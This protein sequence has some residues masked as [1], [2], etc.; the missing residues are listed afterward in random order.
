MMLFLKECRKVLFSIPF[1][2]VVVVIVAFSS[3]QGVFPKFSEPITKPQATDQSFGMHG[4]DIPEVV[5]P[6]AIASL[7]REFSVNQYS[8]YPIGFYKTV[9][10]NDK[11]QA[12]MAKILATLSGKPANEILQSAKIDSTSGAML[13]MGV[14]E[15]L[16]LD[17]DGNISVALSDDG[18]NAPKTA[19]NITAKTGLDYTDFKVQMA[20]ADKLIGSGSMYSEGYLL[21]NFGQVPI[22]FEEAIANYNLIKNYDKFSGAYSRLFSDYLGIML[23]II[24]VFIA[25]ALFLK[26]RSAKMNELV[27]SR[28]VPAWHVVSSRFFA[29]ITLVMIPTI[30]ICYIANASMWGMHSGEVIDYLAPLKYSLGWMLP[31]IM[32]SSAVG[33]FFT[34]LTDTPIAIIIQGFWW[35]IDINL[36]VSNIHGRYEW[37]VLSPR[38]NTIQA[39]NFAEKLSTLALNRSIFSLVAIAL[40]VATIYVYSQKRKGRLNG[41]DHFKSL[42]TN[43]KNKPTT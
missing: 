30:T 6:A 23:S 25:V 19:G 24:P 2:V 41:Y 33:M 36:G 11:K 16:K 34:V 7:Y 13:T 20:A 31:S 10:L 15:T 1:A 5:V 4:K 29:I 38:H 18:G 32:I 35:F 12:E 14:D 21:N 9:R 28:T 37:Y 27:F 17:K 43:R 39:E 26:D 42:F 22:T 40:L 8:A 3:M